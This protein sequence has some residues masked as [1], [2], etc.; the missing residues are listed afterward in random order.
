METSDTAN[1]PARAWFLRGA[2]HLFSLPAFVLIGAQIG[3]AALAREAGFSLGQALLL[4]LAVWALPSQVVFV[5]IVGSGASLPAVMLA[6]GLSAV[7]FM[8]MVMSWTPVVRTPQTPRWLLLFMSWFVAV[9]AWVFAMAHLPDMPRKARLPFFAGFAIC[10]TVMNAAV[11]GLAYLVIG[12]VPPMIAAML[13]FLTPIYFLMALW[14]AARAHADRFALGLGLV[15]GPVF[16]ILAPQ[17]DLL[18]AGLIG[19][20]LAYGLGRLVRKPLR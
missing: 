3:F 20:T 2:S 9:T 14:G 5:G 17:I 18:A 8:P 12:A 11:V 13:V 19:G 16:T 4:T 15:L 1:V 7:R 6:V 10:L